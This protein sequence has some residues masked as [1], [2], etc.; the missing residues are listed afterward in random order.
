MYNRKDQNKEC[1]ISTNNWVGLCFKPPSQ[2]K[3][4]VE[5]HTDINKNE[6]AEDLFTT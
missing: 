5:E 3:S 1:L 6:I 4:G 2:D